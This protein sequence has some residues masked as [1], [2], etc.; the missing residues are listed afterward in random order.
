MTSLDP[1]LRRTLLLV[2]LALLAVATARASQRLAAEEPIDFY[3]FWG[4]QA[5]RS[6]A[7]VNPGSPYV[8][9]DSYALHL[10][11][12]ADA[13][14]HVSFRRTNSRR[15]ELD[16]TSPPLLY[17]AFFWLPE[18]FGQARRIFIALQ[19]L[20]MLG[21]V[22]L[23]GRSVGLPPPGSW[24]LAGAAL[25]SFGPFLSDLQVGNV[26]AMQLFG[27]ALALRL[28]LSEGPAG[29]ATVALA[30]LL[31]LF[32]PNQAPAAVLLAVARCVRVGR[33]SALVELGVG[34]AVAAAAVV[35]SGL[36]FESLGVW[37]DWYDYLFG[38]NRSKLTSYPT[39]RGMVSSPVRLGLWTGLNAYAC[40]A[41]LLAVVAGGFVGA[42]LVA[43]TRGRSWRELLG[44]PALMAS[45]GVVAIYAAGPLA[46]YHYYIL[47]LLPA[48]YVFLAGERFDLAA[49]LGALALVV[50]WGP[51][52]EVFGASETYSNLMSFAW[53][54]LLAA[55][56][57][58]V[59]ATET[60]P[61][62][63]S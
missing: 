30:L 39:E 1:R 22:L 42:C 40:A 46:W 60:P 19:L 12:A 44:Q 58:R 53:V 32:K 59:L 63:A 47:A 38:D 28:A 9:L 35:L 5:A 18:D 62:E 27:V 34:V 14:E 2:V 21:G 51:L 17:A 24:V 36:W 8:D 4:I 10:N 49:A 52:A 54:P 55:I 6:M 7:E 48:L 20:G 57:L 16:P 50:Y 29:R 41:L 13:S 31:V 26:N 61:A 23:I 3:H 43:R 56:V 37:G 33:A 15:R 45:V 25:L 11:D